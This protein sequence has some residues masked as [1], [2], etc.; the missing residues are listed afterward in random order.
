MPP[1]ALR[2]FSEQ[3]QYEVKFPLKS[4]VWEGKLCYSQQQQYCCLLVSNEP[5]EGFILL[6]L[7]QVLGCGSLPTCST[8]TARFALLPLPLG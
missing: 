6:V 3:I 4:S 5:A 7:L 2:G 1:A 8:E